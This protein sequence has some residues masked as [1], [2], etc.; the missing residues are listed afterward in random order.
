M[1]LLF[2]F[3]TDVLKASLVRDAIARKSTIPVRTAKNKS[4]AIK[5]ILEVI[6]A[7]VGFSIAS[8]V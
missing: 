6:I 1:F 5:S 8:N 7:K 3:Y 4:V 2:Y